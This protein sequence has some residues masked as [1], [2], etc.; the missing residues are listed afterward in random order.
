MLKNCNVLYYIYKDKYNKKVNS[1]NTNDKEWLDYKNL[2]LSDYQYLSEEEKEEQEE[3]K[4][5]KDDYK[6]L[7]EQIIDEETNINDDLFNKHFRFQRP[8]DMLVLLNKTNDTE[9]NNKLVN[10][11]N[12]GLKDLKKEIK[13]MSKE[14][15]KIEK[16]DEIVRVVEMIVDFNKQNQQGRGLKILAPN[17]MFSRLPITLAQLK[18]E[19]PFI[20]QK[21]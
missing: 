1:L 12:S 6:T 8:S 15:I 10:L 18:A 9:K 17:Q 5:T 14:E 11:I 16:P 7:I 4:P 20:V 3:Q 19:I 21:I 2:R 13:N